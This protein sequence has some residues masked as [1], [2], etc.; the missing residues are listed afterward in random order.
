MADRYTAR[1]RKGL[2]AAGLCSKLALL[3]GASALIGVVSHPSVS[4]AQ[5]AA[6]D[7]SVLETVIVTA[8]R[9]G[10]RLEDVPLTVAAQSGEQLA[11]ANI[12]T[13]RDLA[14]VTPGLTYGA[15]GAFAQPA[16]R[17]I[18]STANGPGN[19]P[20][21]AT[22]V[23]GV[24][25][26]GQT[27]NM[28]DLPDV[29]RIEVLKGPQ[30][31]LFGR[32]ATGGAIRVFTREPSSVLEGKATVGFGTYNDVLA[33]GYV[34]G[35]LAREALTGSLAAY[36]ER[37]DGFST[38]VRTG[39]H[40]GD[41]RS[42]LVRPKLKLIP[43]DGA[44]VVAAATYIDRKDAI[45]DTGIALNG[46]TIGRNDP[47]AIISTT[48]YRSSLNVE[49]LSNLRMWNASLR[50]DAD[51]GFARLTTLSSFTR[52]HSFI[53]Q[54][55]DN[56]TGQ[57]A[58]C[59]ALYKITFPESTYIQE[60][61]LVSPTPRRLSWS[62]GA[63]YYKDDSRWD[64]ININGTTIIYA[65]TKTDAY[66]LFGEA[67]LEIMPNLVLTGGI[68]YSSESK[69]GL[70]G[71]NA[72]SAVAELGRKRFTAWTPRVSLRYKINEGS[73]VYVT[74]NE[75]FKSGGFNPQNLSRLPFDQEIVKA[76]EL[77][78]KL[79][80]GALIFNAAAFHYDQSNIQ[81]ATYNGLVSTIQNA[82]AAK[83]TGFDVD[84]TT[85]LS[86]SWEV[87]VGGAYTPQ[88]KYASYNQAAVVTP[89]SGNNGNVTTSIDASGKRVVRA[90]VLTVSLV[91]TFTA[92][93]EWGR[94]QASASLYYS[95]KYF[96]EVAGRISQPAY[97]TLGA[98][99]ALT[100]NNWPFELAIE[101][102]NLTDH[103]VIITTSII[104]AS[105]GLVYGARRTIMGTISR[106]F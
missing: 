12:Q 57:G 62:L 1:R 85:K 50:G 81:V 78:Y 65:Q 42:V 66:G 98:R 5:T 8:Q 83:I 51:L 94:V 52:V 40:V 27:S 106:K 55:A 43:W 17:A 39:K 73:N 61:N 41:L 96:F 2:T 25:L 59:S 91:P 67:N 34:S 105:D 75:G 100:P 19:D 64:P 13:T 11:R 70:A 32:N 72:R 45:V 101:G 3:G 48:P 99:V 20:S 77:G 102:R 90:P 104:S 56:S 47:T 28:V 53:Q 79:A 49:P 33:K 54:D 86:S 30:G 89:R 29:E 88:A 95:S 14:L 63:F 87:R 23:D 24:Y 4:R 26:G 103:P 84:L 21:V 76:Y 31:T 38:D 37:R 92:D 18:T 80:T 9:R 58:C 68:R 97:A 44:S 46:N 10:E 74:Y 71:L 22:Y 69:V 36:F 93:T 7:T 15:N 35:P 16:I 6:N 60:V 82:A